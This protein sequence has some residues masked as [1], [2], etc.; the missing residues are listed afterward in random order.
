MVDRKPSQLS[1]AARVFLGILAPGLSCFAC[2]FSGIA[3]Q[4]LSICFFSFLGFPIYFSI[5]N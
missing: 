5:L 4:F 3:F 2:A 1:D